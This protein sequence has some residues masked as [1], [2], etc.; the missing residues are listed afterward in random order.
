M[1]SPEEGYRL[2]DLMWTGLGIGV[3]GGKKVMLAVQ[4]TGLLIGEVDWEIF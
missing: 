4:A 3:A 2:T 1:T